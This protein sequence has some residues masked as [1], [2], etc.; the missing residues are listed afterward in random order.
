MNETRRQFVTRGLR[1][2]LGVAAVSGPLGGCAAVQN[3]LKQVGYLNPS[4][5]IV[6]MN[7]TKWGL[8]TLG[9][10]FDVAV[11]N[12]NAVGFTLQGIKYGLDIDGNRLTSGQSETPVTIEAKGRSTTTL[13]F[14]FPLAQTANALVALLS[15]REVSYGLES[16]FQIGRP[17]FAVTVPANKSGQIPLPQ[18]PRFEVPTAEFR[19]ASISGIQFR[20]VP[21]L[22]NLND[23]DLPIGGFSTNLRIN[24]RPILTNRTDETRTLKA[25]AETAIPIDLNLSLADLGLSAISLLQK[26]R[27][28]WAVDVQLNAGSLKLPFAES[29]Q[30]RLG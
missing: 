5:E 24:D 11:N 16:A 10:T 8:D 30:L 15:K 9:T 4:V 25:N 2:T 28:R 13:A 7:V 29:G 6:D 17:D 23:F 1:S 22:R 19:G 3:V 12:P 14:D 26:P 18:I 20:V 27:L 21:A